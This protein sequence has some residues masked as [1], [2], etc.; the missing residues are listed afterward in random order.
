MAE[1]QA[2]DIK[3]FYEKQVNNLGNEIGVL[4]QRLHASEKKS[5]QPS[6]LLLQLQEEMAAMKVG[7]LAL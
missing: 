3:D 4:R 6:P 1:K 5:D 2:S 7:N